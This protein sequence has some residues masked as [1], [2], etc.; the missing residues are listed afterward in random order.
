[1]PY[2][3]FAKPVLFISR[4][5][6]FAPCRWNGGLTT[7]EIVRALNNYVDFLAICPEIEI[8]LSV[9]RD[10]LQVILS[11]K[12]KSLVQINNKRDFTVSIKSFATNVF[13]KQKD[14]DGF[15]LRSK[16]PSCGA[17]SVKLFKAIDS[18]DPVAIGS[19]VFAEIVQ[20]LFPLHPIIEESDL[21]NEDLRDYF[22][23]RVFTLA[24]FR[25]TAKQQSRDSLQEFHTRNHVLLNCFNPR[26]VS[27]LDALFKQNFNH[28][29]TFLASEYYSL[30]LR[31]L[32][33]RP[34]REISARNLFRVLHAYT[35][36]NASPDWRD[37]RESLERYQ[38]GCVSLRMLRS[39]LKTWAIRIRMENIL[40][41]TFCE[42]YPVFL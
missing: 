3:T 2:N 34:T 27:L 30:L 25:V 28:D 21:N 20:K 39:T 16:S 13:D 10:P 11:R 17:Y 32:H 8:G 41:Q 38:K 37:V 9:P 14:L 12:K 1:L 22:L 18:T 36:S 40:E 35:R 29:V 7:N 6:E 23:T 42:P 15:L 33:Q 31:I 5:I 4:C 26:L 19:G 24:A